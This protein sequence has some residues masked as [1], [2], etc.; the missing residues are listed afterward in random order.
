VHLDAQ[1][2]SAAPD[3]QRDRRRIG[4]PVASR[5]GAGQA[6]AGQ[7][8]AAGPRRALLAVGD[9]VGDQLAG[10][11]DDH[12]ERVGADRQLPGADHGG[13][14]LACPRRRDQVRGEL[15][16]RVPQRPAGVTRR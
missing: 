1:F 2:R 12:V 9:R 15:E 3:G 16:P 8:P 5:P 10:Q 11:Q 7:R 4:N 13:D 14:V 6:G